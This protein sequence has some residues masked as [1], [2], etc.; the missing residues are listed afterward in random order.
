MSCAKFPGVRTLNVAVVGTGTAGSAS[1]LFLARLGHRVQVFERVEVPAP[2]GAGIVL[3]PTGLTVLQTLG[4]REAVVARG[5]RLDALWCQRPGGERVLDLHYRTLGPELS[6]LGIHRGVLFGALLEAVRREPQVTLHCGFD[7]VRTHQTRE[8]A[9]LHERTRGVL[10]PFDLVVVA[11]GARSNLRGPEAHV[12]RYPWGALW[13]LV[14]DPGHQFKERLF[15]VVDGTRTLVGLLPTGLGPTGTTPHVSLFWSLPVRDLE[16]FG[17]RDFAAWKWQVLRD[18]PAAE[19]VLA[20]LSSAKDLL[21]SEYHDVVMWPWHHQRTVFVG[22]AAH[23][24]SPQLGQGANLALVDALVLAQAVATAEGSEEA[25]A[26]YSRTR[27]RH[28]DWYQWLTR[29]LTPFFQ[30]DH[31][32]LGPL[33]DVGLRAMLQVPFFREQMI[34]GMTGASL[35]PFGQR[36]PLPELSRLDTTR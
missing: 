5:E 19:P 36:V 18:V 10:G 28:L 34:I 30:S 26:Q 33:R 35:G 9:W 3:Q 24:T 17:A 16:A 21:F 25:L 15:Q 2:A 4:L 1:A 8:G 7:I 13:A 6:G 32:V 27:R 23:A 11:N 20:Q 22:D 12:E 14:P 29:W 31:D